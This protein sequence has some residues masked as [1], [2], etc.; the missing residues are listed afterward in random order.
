MLTEELMLEVRRL[1]IRARRRVD[2]LF[3]GQYHSAFKGQ[4]IEFAEVRE[5]QPGDEVRT[6]DW[7]VTARTGHPFVKRF[8]EERQLTII[9]AVD[10]A[11]SSAFG[12]VQRTKHT[13]AKETGAVLALAAGR[14][15]DR[16]GIHLFGAASMHQ[17]QSVHLPPS[18]G[19]THSLRLIRALI[20]AAPGD[21]SSDLVENLTVLGRT[22]RRRAVIF[23]LSDFLSGLNNAGEPEW[24]RP[25]RMLSQKHEVVALQLTDPAEFNLPKAGLITMSD[26]ISGRRFTVDTTSKRVRK[27]FAQAAA[28]ENELITKSFRR[29]KVDCVQLSTNRS[30]GDDLAKYFR[31]RE[32]RA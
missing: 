4:G 2:D 28:K 27:K 22:H 16:V 1:E 32:Q 24:A 26:P 25:L 11:I 3:G 31:Y 10:C 20:D 29:A 30:F 23:V 14:N 9:L 15:N 12:T 8:V 19:K 21:R 13:L 7:N 18:K 6:I 17:G 5:Y